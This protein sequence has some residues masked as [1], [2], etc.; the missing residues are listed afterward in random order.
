[1]RREKR[2]EREEEV[3]KSELPPASI[4]CGRRARQSKNEEERQ[5]TKR[6]VLLVGKRSERIVGGRVR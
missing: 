2:Q 3:E 6:Y 5:Q 4:R 1:M